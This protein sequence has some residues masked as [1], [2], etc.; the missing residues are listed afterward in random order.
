MRTRV[1]LRDGGVVHNRIHLAKRSGKWVV[2]G[3]QIEAR[4]PDPAAD[5]P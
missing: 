1:V 5:Q 3:Y 4:H 2:V